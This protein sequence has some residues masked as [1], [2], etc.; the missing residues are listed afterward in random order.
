MHLA[1]GLDAVQP[2]YRHV[3]DQNAR[4]EALDKTDGLEAVRN[5]AYDFE[6]RFPLD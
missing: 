1:G 4:L 3:H 6:V 5:L 2:W